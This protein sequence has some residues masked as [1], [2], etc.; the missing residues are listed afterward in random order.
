MGNSTGDCAAVTQNT[1]TLRKRR[2][3]LDYCEA[4]EIISLNKR[5]RCPAFSPQPSNSTS[6]SADASAD[7]VAGRTH[8]L[9]QLRPDAHSSGR[10]LYREFQSPTLSSDAADDTDD[11]PGAASTG[12]V[13]SQFAARFLLPECSTTAQC[14]PERSSGPCSTIAPE[15]SQ[16]IT[17]FLQLTPAEEEWRAKL[18]TPKGRAESIADYEHDVQLATKELRSW[19]LLYSEDFRHVIAA[20]PRVFAEVQRI[21]RESDTA[22]ACVLCIFCNPWLLITCDVVD[23]K[24]FHYLQR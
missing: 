12:C 8:V 13:S 2:A 7:S 3:E 11:T 9:E 20:V 4:D 18:L 5:R 22:G 19:Q 24:T 1:S 10:L 23:K 16:H 15:P 17:R 6:D 14:K 21:K